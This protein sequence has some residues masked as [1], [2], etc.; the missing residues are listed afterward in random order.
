[1]TMRGRGGPFGAGPYG[2]RSGDVPS[3]PERVV[4]HRTAHH[5]LD[6]TAM[7]AIRIR[8]IVR[9]ANLV[10]REL[11]GPVSAGALERLRREVT[12]GLEQ[13]D[14]ILADH[15]M[16]P[17]AMS[18]AARKAYE[19][20]KSVDFS[21]VAAS[22]SPGGEGYYRGS[23][24][25]PGVRRFLRYLLDRLARRTGPAELDGLHAE[26]RRKTEAIDELLEAE[27]VRPEHLK[28]ESR[29]IRAWLAYFADRGHFDAYVAA[30]G[31]AG[32]AFDGQAAASPRHAPPVM[33]H[34]RPMKGVYRIR[35][36]V[37]GTGVHL[38]TPMISFSREAF[39]VLAAVA[40]RKAPGGQFVQEQMLGPAYQDIL[41]E[42]ELLAGGGE[43][44]AGVFHDLAAAFDRVNAAFFDS[45]M[46]RPR[47]LWSRA[48]TMRKFGHYDAVHD[49]V[50]IS[51]TADAED[52][53]AFVVDFLVY[54][55]LLHKKLGVTWRGGRRRAHT[56]QF[57]RAE[58]RFP[59]LAEA[60]AALKRLAK[61]AR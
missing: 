59:R 7:A 1:M 60:E 25:L 57:R 53:P 11:A 54:H 16:G 22:D 10:R 5:H 6:K 36:A 52:V 41:A 21:A 14:V 32:P 61:A 37:G 30:V 20:L 29:A 44:G 49:T 50:M 13:L 9:L 8:G 55:E 24:R 12:D 35:P 23:V 28:D 40:F 2:R 4:R 34:F 15:G 33:V 58:R 46:P 3:P 26:I 45:A 17:E 39:D 47:L 56:P 51:A 31:R 43:T 38:P 27:S 19:F 42:M 48:L 18:P